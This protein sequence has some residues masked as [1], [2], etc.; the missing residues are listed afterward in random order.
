MEE[1]W[2]YVSCLAKPN[3]LTLQPASPQVKDKAPNFKAA[4]PEL[5]HAARRCGRLVW[6]NGGMMIRRGKLKELGEESTK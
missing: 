2:N 3:F 4:W 5:L 6:D 1:W